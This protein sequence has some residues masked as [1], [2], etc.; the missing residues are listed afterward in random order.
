MK[1]F[2]YRAILL[3]TICANLAY[4]TESSAA[5]SPSPVALLRG[6]EASRMKH[7][8]VEAKFTILINTP[9]REISMEC[10]VEQDGTKRRFEVV[11]AK[12]VA[13]SI[14]LVDGDI[15]HNLRRLKHEDVRLNDLKYSVMVAN[16]QAFDPRIL[17][18]SDLTPA[19]SSVKSLLWYENAK[20]LLVIGSEVVNG[21]SV[22]HVK[23]AMSN[24]ESHYWIEEP[25]FRVHRRTIKWSGGDIAINSEFDADDRR[26]PFPKRVEVKRTEGREVSSRIFQVA[27]FRAGGNVAPERFTMKSMELPLNTAVVDYRINRIVGYWNGEGLSQGPVLQNQ[28]LA[29]PSTPQKRTQLRFWVIGINIGVFSVLC[30]LGVWRQRV[31]SLRRL[32]APVV[33]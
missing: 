22:W 33:Q 4:V 15:V 14:T 17:G 11:A 31:R 3:C 13:P 10:S 26:S 28:Q 1:Q 30:V 7:D 8:V 29:E 21:I 32:N 9:P 24:A 25:S 12:G 20:E 27:S 6:V 16:D 19:D 5:E 2:S 18:L 23:A